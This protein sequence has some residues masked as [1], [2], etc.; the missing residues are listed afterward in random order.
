[1]R[2]SIIGS[3]G[4]AREVASWTGGELVPKGQTAPYKEAVIAI[5]DPK[6]RQHEATRPLE[7]VTIM[8]ESVRWPKEPTGRGT[9]ICPGVIA[10]TNVRMGDHVIV[11][12]ACT[13]GHDCELDDYTSLM[14]GVHLSGNVRVGR[15]AY[16]GSGAVVRQGVDIGPWAVIGCGAVVIRDVP[17]GETWVGV[18]ARRLR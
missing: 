4:F 11:N 7:W 18:P 13:I 2:L 6:A 12:L 17:A 14:P 10:T 9:I 5:G 8:H 15:G 16:L 1:M 3:G